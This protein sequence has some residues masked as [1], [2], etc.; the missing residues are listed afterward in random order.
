M[1]ITYNFV[2]LRLQKRFFFNSGPTGGPRLDTVSFRHTVSLIIGSLLS[3]THMEKRKSGSV[4][5]LFIK[6]SNNIEYLL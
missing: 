4:R 3:N 5:I 6:C 1:F 2:A